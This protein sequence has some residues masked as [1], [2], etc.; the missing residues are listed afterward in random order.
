MYNI[1]CSGLTIT[2]LTI[3]LSF[4]CLR[5]QRKFTK[6]SLDHNTCNYQCLHSF[7]VLEI[8][9]GLYLPLALLHSEPLQGESWI[10][11]L[12]PGSFLLAMGF[13]TLSAQGVPETQPE[14]L[15][16]TPPLLIQL[17]SLGFLH[18]QSVRQALGIGEWG[19]WDLECCI[20]SVTAA[21]NGN[22]TWAWTS[23][24]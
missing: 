23:E 6:T 1:P 9:C 2:Y 14:G 8:L 11:V 18:K 3:F 17:S 4:F 5:L 24:K 20:I 12:K 19:A 22:V 21:G 15:L 13:L 10:V 7:Q 16:S